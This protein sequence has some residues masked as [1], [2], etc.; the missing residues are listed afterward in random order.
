[1]AKKRM[2]SNQIVDS[3]AFLDMPLSAQ[4]LYLHLLVRADD[5]GFTNGVRKVMRMTRAGDD[6]LKVLIGKKFVI[7][8]ESGVMVIKHWLIH[9]TIR[10][11]RVI[12]T[13]H[14][15]EK[16]QLAIKD[17]NSYTKVTEQLS[18]SSQAGD[19]LGLEENSIEEGSI[20]EP[21]VEQPAYPYQKI[22]T[23]LNQKTGTHYKATSRKS[24][25]LIKAR[26]NEGFNEK[27]FYTVID[28]KYD[29]WDKT[30]M[31]KFL[32]PE[33]L[34]GPKFEGYLNQVI[35]A[36]QVGKNNLP[37]DIEKPDWWD[38]YEKNREN[39][40]HVSMK[41]V[42]DYCKAHEIN[43]NNCPEDKVVLEWLRK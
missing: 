12:P 27:D 31:S 16:K 20:E 14:Q 22:I 21:I 26:Y 13:A 1:M 6:D 25:D 39:K 5:E 32:R 17:N 30:D 10:H 7:M 35:V 18:G 4:A 2:V 8:F 29:E 15:E 3:D 19:R 36:K 28:K 38:E 37:K 9:N 11:D 42:D 23:Y 33:T 24:R 34:F 40:E 43:I 41:D